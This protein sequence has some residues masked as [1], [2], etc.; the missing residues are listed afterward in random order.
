MKSD[1]SSPLK[2]ILDTRFLVGSEIPSS[3]APLE[4]ALNRALNTVTGSGERMKDTVDVDLVSPPN[5]QS[6]VANLSG[7]DFDLSSDAAT[8]AQSQL[9]SD[10]TSV[11]DRLPAVLDKLMVEAHPLVVEGVPVDFDLQVEKIP[12]YWVTDKD[13]QVWIGA[14]DSDLGDMSGQFTLT[15]SQD[16]LQR[17]VRQAAEVAAAKQGV[18]ILDLD[19]DIQQAGDV[20]TVDVKARVR[21]SIIKAAVVARGQVTY[22]PNSFKFRVDKVDVHSQNPAVAV[23]LKMVQ[24]Q[25]AQFEGKTVDLNSLLAGSGKQLTEARVDVSSGDVRV[26]GKFS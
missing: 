26:T 20:F 18:R 17:A 2:T 11:A 10:V 1:S 14:D 9:S 5:I 6:I 15:I 13:R 22:N 24:S 4:A 23:L 7:L 3:S 16:A 8:K 25:I 19:L 21:K 12:F